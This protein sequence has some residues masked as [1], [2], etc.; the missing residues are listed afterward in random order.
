LRST[1]SLRGAADVVA[2]ALALLSSVQ[3]NLMTQSSPAPVTTPDT[4]GA[5]ERAIEQRLRQ[6]RDELVVRNHLA[7]MDVKD[8]VH[9]LTKELDHLASV[10]SRRVEVAVARLPE[11]AA[12]KTYLALFDANTRMLEIEKAVKAALAGAAHSATVL[13]ETARM[14]AALARLDAKDA[15]EARRAQL[16]T[17][18]H[19]ME[20]RGSQ[21]LTDIEARLAKLA[22]DTNR[23]V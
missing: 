17:K 5:R 6:L 11:E 22:V 3:E 1:V 10:F 14:K 9:E 20:A 4:A 16:R 15:V 19:E 12:I 23:V 13:T 2:L 7:G 8:A 18:L 21:A